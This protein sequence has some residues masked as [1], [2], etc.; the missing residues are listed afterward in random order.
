MAIS[1]YEVCTYVCNP[2][3]ISTFSRNNN[4]YFIEIDSVL[5]NITLALGKYHMKNG[6]MT[7]GFE[8]VKSKR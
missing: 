8:K 6:I 7:D 4:G 1:E 2:V 5:R 3:R